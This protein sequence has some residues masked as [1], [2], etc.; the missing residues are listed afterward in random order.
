[1]SLGRVVIATLVV[2][3]AGCSASHNNRQ[4]T[5]ASAASPRVV[6]APAGVVAGTA[7]SSGRLWVLAGTSTVKALYEIDQSSGTIDKT[8]PVGSG[9]NSAAW[10]PAGL[11]AVG[12]SGPGTGAVYLYDAGSGS[13]VASIPVAGPV[14][15]LSFGS[16]DSLY[17]LDGSAGAK[18]LS[19]IDTASHQ[20]TVAIN[21]PAGSVGVGVDPAQNVA[22][23]LDG[24]SVD[25]IPLSK[26]QA[27]ASFADGGD[28]SSLSVAPDGQYLY[29]L[30]GKTGAQN[31][32]VVSIATESVVRVLPAAADSVSVGVSSDGTTLYDFVGSPSFGNV[33]AIT[34]PPATR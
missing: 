11:I 25:R 2:G 30:K 14:G 33:Q 16:P 19:V 17:V 5:T 3:A 4:P 26:G 20:V 12:I 24:S 10:S 22:Y 27:S 7:G 29:V 8:V 34:L 6:P 9:A 18:G 32:A 1:M 13:E 28:G 23:T 31:V 21:L 15:A